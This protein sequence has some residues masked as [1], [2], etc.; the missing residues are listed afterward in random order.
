MEELKKG[1][2]SE[3]ALDEI[4]AG[5]KIDKTKLRNALIAA[6]VVVSVAA[7]IGISMGVMKHN[8]KLD[9]PKRY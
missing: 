3:D 4:A 2:I 7:P 5:G 6:G 1:I 9:E 8:L